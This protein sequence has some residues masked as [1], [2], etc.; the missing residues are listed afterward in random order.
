MVFV[1]NL[2]LT[3]IGFKTNICMYIVQLYI[4]VK[5]LR[6]LISLTRIGMGGL[7]KLHYAR[8]AVVDDGDFLS[9]MVLLFCI[10]QD[11]V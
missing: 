11:K 4:T 9:E 5:L 8:Q 2:K 10:K 7:P 1:H 6:S 3:N